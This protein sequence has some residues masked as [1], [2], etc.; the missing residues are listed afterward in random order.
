MQWYGDHQAKTNLIQPHD[1]VYN[2]AKDCA[3][4]AILHWNLCRL[5]LEILLSQ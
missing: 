4:M 1:T 5:V 2:M 3:G